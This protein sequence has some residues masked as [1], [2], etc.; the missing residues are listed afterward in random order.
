MHLADCIGQHDER[1]TAKIEEKNGQNIHRCNQMGN[2]TYS[3]IIR[4]QWEKNSFYIIRNDTMTNGT[5]QKHARYPSTKMNSEKFFL[6]IIEIWFMHFRAMHYNSTNI[7][8]IKYAFI[9]IPLHSICLHQ[10]IH[11]E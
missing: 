10:Y 8:I 7:H 11:F 4:M 3:I 1:E 2:K 5:P 6:I 9:F